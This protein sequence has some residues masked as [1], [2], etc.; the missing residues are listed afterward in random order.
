MA[1]HRELGLGLRENSYQRALARK[2]TD[3]GLA[4]EQQQLFE[5]YEGSDNVRL[6]GYDIP[7]F[8]VEG[9]VLVE[10]KALREIDTATWRK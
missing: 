1:V 4:F 7:V 3:A 9:T 5:V 2:L 8:V 6:A 10:I